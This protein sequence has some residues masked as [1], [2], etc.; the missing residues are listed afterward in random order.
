MPRRWVPRPHYDQT[1]TP[2]S[3]SHPG[4]AGGPSS[5]IANFFDRVKFE[6]KKIKKGGRRKIFFEKFDVIAREK[7]LKPSHCFFSTENE[8]IVLSYKLFRSRFP[9]SPTSDASG[10]M[11]SDALCSTGN[12]TGVCAFPEPNPSALLLPA[13]VFS[14]SPD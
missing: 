13:D 6:A 7:L 8:G 12:D 14:G 10:R 1:G 4:A 2:S 5:T 9:L 11:N 3:S